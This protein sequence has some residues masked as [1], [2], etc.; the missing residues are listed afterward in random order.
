MKFYLK[1]ILLYST[2]AAIVLS[3]A[4]IRPYVTA[5]IKLSDTDKKV[6]AFYY[7]WYGNTT[8]FSQT[9]AV[10]IQD[11][12]NWIH[13]ES[14]GYVP[15]VN[16]CS[17]NTPTMGWYDSADPNLIQYHLESAAWAGIDAFVVSYWGNN[18]LERRNF[19]HMLQ[20]AA[21]IKSP[22]KLSL[23]FEIFMN[24]L[25]KMPE[26]DAAAFL[27]GEF[28]SIYSIMT[29]PTYSDYVWMENGKPVLF[30]Y[31][32]QAISANEWANAM[33][34]LDALN[35]SF[36]LVGDRPGNQ[37]NYNQFFDAAHQYDV[38][39]PT[40]RGKYLIDYMHIKQSCA[41]FDQVFIA[42]VAPGYD[43][44][45]VRPG[46]PPLDRQSGNTYRQSWS[47]AISL[48]PDWITITSWNEWH[49]GTEIEPS[50]ENGDLALN[51]T[52]LFIEEFKSGEYR[53]LRPV[54]NV[55]GNILYYFWLAVVGS[56]V[57][58]AIF[59]FLLEVVLTAP[60]QDP[61]E[62]II[63]GLK[64]GLSMLFQLEAWGA[65]L[66]LFILEILSAKFFE[67]TGTPWILLLPATIFMQIIGTRL[68]YVKQ[69]G[70][71]R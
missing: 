4:V 18:S 57:L 44:H 66:A 68:L 20:I 45:K 60:P 46:N 39:A 69:K 12:A 8:N 2:V 11:N 59:I 53:V 34:A 52:K 63:R 58:L 27:T 5:G 7:G 16:A 15:P 1:A 56:I 70:G 29:D 14:A 32:V 55:Y 49:E 50:I 9:G 67:V 22:V 48:N 41:T 6:A 24:S 54:P 33:A 17:T 26:K 62:V 35:V 28:Q 36:F 65:L 31:V 47:N 71:F 30:V 51:Q 64:R 19:I 37:A 38:Y 40:Y 13:W 61:N 10:S 25:D 23:Y 43:D 42:G 3:I 21:A